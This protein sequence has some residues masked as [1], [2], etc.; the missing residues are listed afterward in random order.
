MK[1]QLEFEEA[2]LH[3]MIDEYFQR[4]GFKVKDLVAVTEKF[5][6]IFPGGIKITAEPIV[7]TATVAPRPTVVSPL[8][9][10][11]LVEEPTLQEAYETGPVINTTMSATDLFDPTPGNV[12]SRDEQ[13]EQSRKEVESI[14]AQSKAIE[15]EK[16]K[17]E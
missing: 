3:E 14:V 9:E 13:L 12:P 15:S 6:N 16:S 10:V 17:E 2:D 11:E 1:L 5:S 7:V 4:R 8:P